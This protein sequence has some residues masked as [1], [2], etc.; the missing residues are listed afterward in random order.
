MKTTPILTSILLAF[1]C[2]CQN[3][4]GAGNGATNPIDSL[5]A[6]ASSEA[7]ED[8]Y[9]TPKKREHP[10]DS[11]FHACWAENGSTTGMKFC[12]YD[13]MVAW[14]EEMNK[15]YQ[16]LLDTLQGEERKK[17][18]NSQKQWL[19]YSEAEAEFLGEFYT[20]MEGTLWGLVSVG[21]SMDKMKS[22]AL[23]LK[24]H[25]G[26]ITGASVRGE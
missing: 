19:E 7:E 1:L 21:S 17:M 14:E 5:S 8:E 22:R 24:G 10:I 2:S 4:Q 16:L 26:S 6:T 18:I 23:E 13:A 12:T 3:D 20:N 15:Y 9:E 25:Y 11:A